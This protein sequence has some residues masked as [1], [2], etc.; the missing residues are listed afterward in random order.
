MHDFIDN[1]KKEYSL[2]VTPATS[3]IFYISFLVIFFS[4]VVSLSIIG[5]DSVIGSIINNILFS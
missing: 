1:L 4:I 2:I 3:E 5:V